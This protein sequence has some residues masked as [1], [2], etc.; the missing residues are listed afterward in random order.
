M[1]LPWRVLVVGALFSAALFIKQVAVFD[2]SVT[3]TKPV[4]APCQHHAA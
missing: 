2:S 1:R 4:S 3:A